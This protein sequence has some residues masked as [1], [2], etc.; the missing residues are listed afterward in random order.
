MRKVVLGMQM[1]L[2]GYVATVD[3]GLDWAFA[4]FDAELGLRLLRP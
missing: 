2:D 3:G 4:D 1:S